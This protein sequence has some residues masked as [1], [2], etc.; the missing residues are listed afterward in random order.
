MF[1]SEPSL[2]QRI[3]RMIDET[4]IVDPHTHIRC[5]QPDAPDLAS[6]MSYHWV[7][8]ELRAVGMPAADLDPALP[9]DERVRRSIPY[10]RR[11]RNTA[12][13]WC[14]YRIFRDLYDFHDPH[15]TESNYRD[16]IDKVAATGRDPAW[17]PQ[18]PP[19][20]LQHPDRRHQPGQ[21]ERRPGEEPR[22]RP[23]H[24]RRPLPVLP[25]RRHRPDPVLRRPDDEGRILRGPRRSS[26]ASGPRPP[27]GS[28]SL[29]RDWLDRTV[30]GP[31]RF[32]QHVHPDRAAVPAPRRGARPVRPRRRPPTAGTLDRRGHR[33]A[34]PVRDLEGAGLAPREPQGVPDR[35]GGRVLHLRRQEHPAVPGD[36]DERDGAGLP[37]LRQRPV[38][39]DDGLR[40]ADPRGRPSWPGSSP[41]STPRATG[42]TT[43]SRPRSSG[44]SA[45]ACRWRR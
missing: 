3:E 30:T 1:T 44:S 9:A 21:P 10:L 33:R 32:T 29:L 36:L 19:R 38:R 7:Q 13:A 28:R 18:R 25:G 34:G 15:L 39:P 31:V 43:S 42:G 45:C 16:L 14:L 12:M 27:S 26:S 8:T 35:R 11:M 17:A 22:Q 41:T 2:A 5:D 40:R 24:A 6:L 20:P 4:P 23:V 37:P